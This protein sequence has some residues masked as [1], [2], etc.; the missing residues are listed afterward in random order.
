MS[1]QV[2]GVLCMLTVPVSDISIY[3]KPLLA[4]RGWYNRKPA[5]IQAKKQ[6]SSRGADVHRIWGPS[7]PAQ[8]QLWVGQ[9]DPQDEE[10]NLGPSTTSICSIVISSA[11]EAAAVPLLLLERNPPAP[12]AGRSAGSILMTSRRHPLDQR[13]KQRKQ[14]CF[15]VRQARSIPRSKTRTGECF[16]IWTG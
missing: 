6:T 9:D 10:I 12:A 11:Q 4:T 14:D 8:A 7:R 1:I 16:R 15:G 2:L 3:H 5:P 13:E